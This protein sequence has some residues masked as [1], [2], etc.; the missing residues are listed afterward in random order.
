MDWQCVIINLIKKEEST[1][2]EKITITSIEKLA[3]SKIPA[4]LFDM[5]RCKKVSR[6]KMQAATKNMFEE[7]LK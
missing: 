1:K 3:P 6:K 2:V 4:E 7:T 5:Q